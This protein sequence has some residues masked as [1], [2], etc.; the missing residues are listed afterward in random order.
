MFMTSSPKSKWNVSRSENILQTE[1][2]NEEKEFLLY[3][4]LYCSQLGWF[5]WCIYNNDDDD[6]TKNKIGNKER[7]K[8]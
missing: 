7:R 5:G 2:K 4:T 1:K 6:D 3:R 8:V